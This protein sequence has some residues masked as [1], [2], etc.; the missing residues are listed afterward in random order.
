MRV[1]KTVSPKE[2]CSFGIQEYG[3]LLFKPYRIICRV[4]GEQVIIYAR[5]HAAAPSGLARSI[6]LRSRGLFIASHRSLRR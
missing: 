4:V 3:Q 5:D 6:R 1:M 2:L